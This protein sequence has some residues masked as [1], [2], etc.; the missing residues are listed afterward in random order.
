MNDTESRVLAKQD[1]VTLND[2]FRRPMRKAAEVHLGLTPSI[3]LSILSQPNTTRFRH[4][5]LLVL[6]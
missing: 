3:Y 6:I 4:A 1:S 2:P 5:L